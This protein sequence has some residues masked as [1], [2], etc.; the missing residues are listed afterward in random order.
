M[1]RDPVAVAHPHLM[2]FPGPDALEQRAVL[3]DLRDRRGRT[4]GGRP[5]FDLAAELGAHGL[6]AVADAEHRNAGLEYRIVGARGLPMST[7]ECG[8][9]DRI[10]AFGPM[11][12]ASSARWKGTISE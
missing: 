7:V 6:L 2:R 8:P 9:P 4:R 3:R 1:A 10:T 12:R 5:A 11:R